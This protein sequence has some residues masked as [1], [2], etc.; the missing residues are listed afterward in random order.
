MHSDI[1]RTVACA[2]ALT[3]GAAAAGTIIT[4]DLA[5]VL[6][7]TGAL[8]RIHADPRNFGNFGVPVAG[9]YDCDGDGFQD[10]ALAVIRLSLPGR[11]ACGGVSL[12]F[13][14]GTIGG[15]IDTGQFPSNVLSIAGDAVAETCGNE[16][17]MDDVT[18]DGTGDLLICRQNYTLPGRIG[19]GALT[20]L[21]GGPWLRSLAASGEVIDLRTPPPLLPLVTFTGVAETDR[22]GIWVRTGDVDGDGVADILVGADQADESPALPNRG[23]AWL[24]RGGSHLFGTFTV[25]LAD[26]G[27]TALE[28]HVVR[29]LPPTAQP[30]LDGA[31]VGDHFGATCYILDLDGNGQGEVLVS[32]T[33]S[34]ASASIGAFGAP[35]GSARSAGG[36]ADGTV[37]IAWDTNFP[38]TAWPDGWTFAIDQASEESVID[39]GVNNRRFGEELA[40]GDFDGDGIPDLFVADLNGNG[41]PGQ[42]GRINA[43]VGH[44]LYNAP[45]LRNRVYD[46]D[47]PPGDIVRTDLLGATISA[48]AGDTMLFADFDRDGIDDAGFGQPQDDP[49]NRFDAGTVTV[50]FGQPGGWG[51][52]IDTAPASIANSAVDRITVIQGAEGGNGLLLGDILC[53]SASMGD[54]NG[55]GVPDL[56][57]N[58]MAGD[59]PVPMGEDVGNLIII[60]GRE[61][62]GPARHGLFSE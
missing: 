28:G 56:L 14:D 15:V 40:G 44:V 23:E 17:W 13:G 27:A 34:R 45:L 18:G 29:I 47:S 30:P 50:L 37:Y 4:L 59:S 58:E 21:P 24:I 16:I 51:S 52:F 3:A 6:P 36:T 57:I 41:T 32:S 26:F 48:I 46:L 42:T 8:T 53:Y 39:G 54:M 60:D 19:C 62:T 2:M 25:D 5:T 10:S 22:L 1:G 55:D 35:A 33:I 7:E 11:L 61:L 9:P 12:V 43:G 20:I 38:A 31:D 49:L